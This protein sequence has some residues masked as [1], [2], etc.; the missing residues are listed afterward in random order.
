MKSRVLVS[1]LL[2]MFL[3]QFGFIFTFSAFAQEDVISITTYYPAPYGSY[4]ELA[5]RR[6][7]VGTTYGDYGHTVPDS[8]VTIE[9]AI[10]LGTETPSPNARMTV[11]GGDV[12]IMS[13]SDT[14][15]PG[16]IEPP[17]N[18]EADLYVGGQIF[19][20]ADMQAMAF[21]L[22][23]PGAPSTG[24]AYG[25]NA[26]HPAVFGTP[27]YPY[28]TIT[29]I[30][31][32]GVR[33][34]ALEADYTYFTGAVN[35]TSMGVGLPAGELPNATLDIRGSSN[36]CVYIAYSEASGYQQCPQYTRTTMP[37]TLIISETAYTTGFTDFFMCCR[38]CRDNATA[39]GICDGL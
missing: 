5:A 7:R 8:C 14:G 26:I 1:V 21:S 19:S 39:D 4:I 25:T 30:E 37:Y 34:I 36:S 20:E 35:F 27:S 29:G 16:I 31:F 9:G 32:A 12:I 6:I 33:R 13:A 10:G 2:M 23:D 24:L 18:T 15:F 11:W 28:F 22:R 3:L 17:G 38:A